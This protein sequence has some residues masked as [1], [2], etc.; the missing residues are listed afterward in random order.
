MDAALA[1]AAPESPAAGEGPDP[2]V[3]LFAQSCCPN[4]KE[5]FCLSLVDVEQGVD[6]ILSM[7]ELTKGEKELYLMGQLHPIS[8]SETTR[9]GA[10][11]RINYTYRFV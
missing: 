2:L 1:Q 3:A 7:R 4:K 9:K 11:S 10:R 5:N 6:H 8:T